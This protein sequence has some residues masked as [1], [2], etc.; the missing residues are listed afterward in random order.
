M[1]AS[2]VLNATISAFLNETATTVLNQSRG[3]GE[4]SAA[5]T[6]G[7]SDEHF[8][9]TNVI[10][11]FLTLQ[12]CQLTQPYGS[13]LFHSVSGFFWR[14]NPIAALVEAVTI[15]WYLVAAVLRSWRKDRAAVLKELQENASA[16]LLLRGA[17]G[18]ADSGGL[19]QK[20]MAGSFL[21]KGAQQALGGEVS[22]QESA[23]STGASPPEKEARTPLSR[24]PRWKRNARCQEAPRSRPSTRSLRSPR[25]SAKP[26]APTRWC[27]ASSASPFS[28]P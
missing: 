5:S 15:L 6:D 11:M 4:E 23:L 28:L 2:A 13:L 25:S 21:D 16:L 9:R 12:L 10:G 3:A 24:Q 26:S 1:N 17:I 14:C 7:G 8:T 27:T 19:M 20:L 18:K 22:E